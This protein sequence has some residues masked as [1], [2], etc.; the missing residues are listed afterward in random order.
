MEN[1]IATD[2]RQISMI[3]RYYLG[4][5]ENFT[6]FQ[7]FDGEKMLLRRVAKWVEKKMI[8]GETFSSYESQRSTTA[9]TVVGE[10]FATEGQ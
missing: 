5:H 9:Q 4:L 6:T 8:L 10:L 3:Y 2:E 7:L 1:K